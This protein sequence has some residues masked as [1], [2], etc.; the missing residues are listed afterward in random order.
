MELE[1]L[2]AMTNLTVR[3]PGP[4]GYGCEAVLPVDAEFCQLCGTEFHGTTLYDLR[5]ADM[6][7]QL[8]TT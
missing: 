3:C 1:R 8:Y 2:G 4:L 6:E 5:T 7:A